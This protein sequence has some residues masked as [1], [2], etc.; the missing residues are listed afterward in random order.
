[1]TVEQL[2]YEESRRAL[3][4][5]KV[6]LNELRTRAGT[7]LA[8][9]AL[10]T[11]FLGGEALDA[12]EQIQGPAQTAVYAFIGLA[13]LTVLILLPWGFRWSLDP[14]DL[15]ANYVDERPQAKIDEMLRN[16]AL[17]HDESRGRNQWKVTT[18]TWL[19]RAV[20]AL[21]AV[22]VVAWLEAL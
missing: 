13:V 2:A 8:I 21:L 14:C 4:V 22:E 20:P 5:Q 6:A 16:L 17:Y 3:E 7:L 11:T 9:A 18:L 19:F 15:V 1:V 12:T 10:V